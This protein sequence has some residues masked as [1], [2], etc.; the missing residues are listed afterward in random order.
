MRLA[1]LA[2][3]LLVLAFLAARAVRRRR[4][5]WQRFKRLRT[6]A[7]RQRVYRRWLLES[8]V[9]MGG[10]SGVLLLA[11]WTLLGPAL[12]AAQ[13]WAPA[14]WLRSQLGTGWGAGVAIGAA[15]LVVVALVLPIV[16][17]RGRVDE[18]PAIGDV[19]ALLPRNRRELPYGAALGISAGVFEETMFR[20]A[21]PALIFGIVPNGPLAFLAASLVFGLLHVYQG[22]TGV[23]FATMLGLALSALYVVTGVIAAPILLHSLLDLRSLVLVPALLGTALR[24]AEADG[25]GRHPEPGPD[26]ASGSDGRSAAPRSARPRRPTRR[27]R[28]GRRARHRRDCARR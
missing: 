1:L 23:L 2:L 4:R 20:L 27:R 24:P 10:M 19:R 14:A 3:L 17:V 18:I 26:P 9:V 6:T 22:V 12:R 15:V 11:T 21:L 7:S 16:L 13:A 8:I 5:D 28:A 25:A